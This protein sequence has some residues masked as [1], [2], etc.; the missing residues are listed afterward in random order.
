MCIQ[1]MVDILSSAIALSDSVLCHN[2]VT[3]LLNIMLNALFSRD[4]CSL[5]VEV[6][7]FYTFVRIVTGPL[8]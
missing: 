1:Y 2:F 6:N 8:L 5:V 7:L 3:S 4:F